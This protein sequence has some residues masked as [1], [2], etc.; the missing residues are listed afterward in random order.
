[1]L[2]AHNDTIL[3]APLAHVA[4][5]GTNEPSLRSFSFMGHFIGWADLAYYRN[6][7][8]EWRNWGDWCMSSL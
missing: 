4:F 1:M 6:R 7:L 8:G 5:Q 3:A 2:S